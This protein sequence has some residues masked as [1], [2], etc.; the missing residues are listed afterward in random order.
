MTR[1]Q[2]DSDRQSLA[3]GNS[4]NCRTSRGGFSLTEGIIQSPAEIESLEIVGEPIGIELRMRLTDATPGKP[5]LL[6]NFFRV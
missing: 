1:V 5:A 2:I 3:T 6:A 4:S